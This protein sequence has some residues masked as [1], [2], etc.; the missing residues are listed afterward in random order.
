MSKRVRG[1]EPSL[2]GEI[3]YLLQNRAPDF[4]RE[5]ALVGTAWTVKAIAEELGQDTEAGRDA[6][7]RELY[8]LSQEGRVTYR[9]H[10]SGKTLWKLT[11]DLHE[12]WQA[13]AGNGLRSLSFT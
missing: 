6:I 3:E 8:S 10:R 12:K 1:P 4:E 13:F 2:R 9:R 5:C 7:Q 11:D